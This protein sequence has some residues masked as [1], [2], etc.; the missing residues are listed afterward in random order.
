MITRWFTLGRNPLALAV[1]LSLVALPAGAQRHGGSGMGAMHGMGSQMSGMRHDSASCADMSL[2]HEMI[3]NHDRITRSVT[4]LPNGIRTVTESDDSLLA[5]RIKQHAA[6]MTA[7]VGSGKDPGWP[8]ESEALRT[9]YKNS[10]LI[11]TRIEST[12]KGILLEQTSTDS[13]TVSA[14]QKHA[15]EVTA[16]VEGGMEAMHA[17]MMRNRG[18]MMPGGRGV[19]QMPGPNRRGPADSLGMCPAGLQAH[20]HRPPPEPR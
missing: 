11:R 3:V 6:T 8:M 4:D 5:G 7:R 9:L 20:V 16:M 10:A 18:G 2:I 13:A 1:L 12:A 15:A 19:M 14:L 17:G